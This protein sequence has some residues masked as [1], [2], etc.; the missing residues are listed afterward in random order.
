MSLLRCSSGAPR[1]ASM[2]PSSFFLLLVACTAGAPS[3][4]ADA[5]KAGAAGTSAIRLPEYQA[6]K[7]YSEDFV[8]ESQGKSIVMKRSIDNGKIRTA[9]AVDDQSIVMI[10]MGD[11]KG[12]MYVLMPDQ[13]RAMKQTREAQEEALGTK[14]KKPEEAT[15]EELPPPIDI[16]IEDLG[17]ATVDGKAA[18]K[19]RMTYSEGDVLAWFEKETGAPLR[20]EGTVNDQKSLMEWKNRKIEAQPAALF[21]VPK[22]YEL[23]DMDEMMAK[24]KSMGG[25]GGMAKGMMGGMAQGMG[26][27]LGGTI[28]STLGGSLAGPVGAAAGQYL[29]G[30]IGGLLG[31]KASGAVN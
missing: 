19:F 6:P 9:I 26:Q 17:D 11:A 14:A 3:H 22:D 30:K 7:S 4:A 20:M 5:A 18:K 10:E 16:K 8:V 1:S 12:T 27:S 15:E 2:I 31:K 23:T 24:M 29:G 13:K 25:M 21:E 28:G